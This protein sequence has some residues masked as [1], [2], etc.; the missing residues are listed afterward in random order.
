MGDGVLF[1]IS[2]RENPRAL[3][4]VTDDENLAFWHSTTFN[5]AGTKV[6]FTDELGGGV[7]A[8]C[9]EDIGPERGANGS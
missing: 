8:T 6:V 3:S 9:N 7:G 4:R 1:D 2:D 5:N